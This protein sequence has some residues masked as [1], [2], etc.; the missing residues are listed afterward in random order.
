MCVHVSCRGE[1]S[2]TL[3]ES[4]A[5][6]KNQADMRQSDRRVFLDVYTD[7]K[8]LFDSEDLKCPGQDTFTPFRQTNV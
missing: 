2:P 6:P 3:F 1:F 4:L 7:R 5:G 8:P